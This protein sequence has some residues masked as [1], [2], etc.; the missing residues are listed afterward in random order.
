MDVKG[1]EG[2]Y[3]ISETGEIR[4][5]CGKII[6]ARINNQTKSKRSRVS[7]SKKQKRKEMYV[8]KLIYIH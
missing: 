5:K 8:D 3:T 6:Q 7:L 2:L 1:Y 4:N